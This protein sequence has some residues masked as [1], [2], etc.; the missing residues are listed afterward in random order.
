M[1]L[2]IHY[3]NI[4]LT[5]DHPIGRMNGPTRKKGDWYHSISVFSN[6]SIVDLTIGSKIPCTVIHFYGKK[7]SPVLST[8]ETYITCHREHRERKLYIVSAWSD[9]IGVIGD[10]RTMDGY[11]PGHGECNRTINNII[12]SAFK[13]WGYEQI[14]Y[15]HQRN[16]SYNCVGFVDDILVWANT[17]QWNERKEIMHNH[18]GLYI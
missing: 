5:D 18:H 1:G 9:S 12:I 11:N 3:A 13:K 14:P 15:T 10:I 6:T 2:S 4:L 8:F 17:G 7:G 16:E